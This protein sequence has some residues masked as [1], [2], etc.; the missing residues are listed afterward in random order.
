MIRRSLFALVALAALSTPAA[1]LDDNKYQNLLTPVLKSD[2]DILGQ[3][4][5]YPAGPLMVT[6]A[7]VTIPPGGETGWHLH[8]VPLFVYVLEGTVT[9][10]YGERGVR[11]YQPGTGFIEAI[12]WAHN[13]K[14]E[15]TVPVKIMAVYM[16][17]GDKA[18]TEASADP[19]PPPAPKPEIQ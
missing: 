6:S 12:N 2:R 7:I 4:V 11:T 15:G 9:V 3:P 19:N 1:A 10:D 18:N 5:T 14:N 17:G 16:G 13:G 8:E